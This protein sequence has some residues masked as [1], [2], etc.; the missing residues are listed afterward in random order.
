MKA[1]RA[2]L[3]EPALPTERSDENVKILSPA[4]AGPK[5]EMTAVLQYVY[6][7]ILF[8][9]GGEK[10]I[11][12][13][14]LSIGIAEMDHLLLLGSAIEALGAKPIYTAR[15][16]RPFAWYSSAAVCYDSNPCRMIEAD[17]AGER[18]AIADYERMLSCL[19]DEACIAIVER[20]LADE[21]I[22]LETL[23]KIARS[24]CC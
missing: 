16:P 5:S 18:G 17:I 4:Y 23:K 14:L 13:T 15:P 21:R 19:D 24:L 20:I 2:D 12:D 22:H 3:P 7:S 10:E 6:Q 9:A 1:L 11:A 8:A